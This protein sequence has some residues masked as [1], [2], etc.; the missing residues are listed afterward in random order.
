MSVVAFISA[1]PGY[2]PPCP[3][4]SPEQLEPD[5]DQTRQ[6]AL[7]QRKTGKLRVPA[8]LNSVSAIALKKLSP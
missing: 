1:N 2:R 4:V 7:L 8:K 5:D 3:S 6:L